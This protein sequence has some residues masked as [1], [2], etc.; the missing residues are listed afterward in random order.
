MSG[1]SSAWVAAHD[2]TSRT[3]IIPTTSSS[4]TTGRWRMPHFLKRSMASG[5]AVA[6]WTVATPRVIHSPT[7]AAD[8][9]TPSATA[10]TMSR[11]VTIPTGRLSLTTSTDE[12]SF[13]RSARAA[14]SS[15]AVP[16]VVWIPRCMI[17]STSTAPSFSS[18][19]LCKCRRRER[20]REEWPYLTGPSRLTTRP[21]L[22]FNCSAMLRTISAT[23]P[24]ARHPKESP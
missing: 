19:V 21:R 24:A 6:G 7:R 18:S 2:I 5:M 23:K 22:L 14:S 15:V 8:T 16:V 11:S 12:M 1:E 20:H 17:S 4:S 3:E 9:S 13:T 10:A